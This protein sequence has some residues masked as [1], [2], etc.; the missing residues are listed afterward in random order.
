MEKIYEF[1][2]QLWLEAQTER[3]GEET[4]A[5]APVTPRPSKKAKEAPS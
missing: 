5:T 1:L 3:E 4:R 2:R